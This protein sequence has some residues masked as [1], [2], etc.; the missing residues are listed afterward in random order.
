MPTRKRIRF[1]CASRVSRYPSALSL[2]LNFCF[3]FSI[4]RRTLKLVIRCFFSSVNFYCVLFQKG[5]DR[6]VYDRSLRQC[7]QGRA[8][9]RYHQLSP[10]PLACSNKCRGITWMVSSSAN[11]RR[12]L[13]HSLSLAPPNASGGVGSCQFE[14]NG[15]TFC[16]VK[17]GH[18]YPVT[19]RP[20]RNFLIWRQIFLSSG[21]NFLIWHFIRNLIIR[22]FAPDD[23]GMWCQI[24][25]FLS[26]LIK[27]NTGITK[28]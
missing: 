27:S 9:F 20:Q 28:S 18:T 24:R 6:S 11:T 14:T 7:Q 21:A 10:S 17:I 1:L 25:K 4:Q 19:E 26:G 8:L 5:M 13:S 12:P 15:S 2:S 22:K 3:Y 23:K 16:G